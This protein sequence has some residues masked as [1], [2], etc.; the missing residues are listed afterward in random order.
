MGQEIVHCSVCGIRLRGSDFDRGEAVR[1]DRAA[2]CKKCSAEII[3]PEP[4]ESPSTSSR[5]RKTSTARI[6]IVTPRRAME[7]A[8]DAP[9]MPPAVLWGAGG[10]LVALIIAASLALGNRAQPP[11]PAPA[12]VTRVPET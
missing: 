1:I 3:P 12:P 7:A 8:P 10:L 4:L 5:K 2:Y 9:S 6:P 11:A